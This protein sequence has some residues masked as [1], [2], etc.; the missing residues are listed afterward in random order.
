MGIFRPNGNPLLKVNVKNYGTE[1][2]VN[3]S[4]NINFNPDQ[5]GISTANSGMLFN[6][7]TWQFSVDLLAGEE[8]N[9]WLEFILDQD[10][11]INDTLFYQI[12]IPISNDAYQAD[13]TVSLEI[14][15]LSSF[16]PNDKTV[17]PATKPLPGETTELVYRI[18]FQNT[19]TD[20]AFN[21]TVIDTLS[22]NLN[23]Y[24]LR[25]LEV[26]HPYDLQLSLIHI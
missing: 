21:V 23:L 20:T 5:Q 13:N 7:T 26:S 4:L 17:F 1:N 6:S 25:M 3:Q 12:E 10:L 18:R 14:P 2:I 19:G 8:Q 11:S 16:D 15:V 24:S 22:E 9:Y